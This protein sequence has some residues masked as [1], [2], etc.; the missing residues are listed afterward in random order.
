MLCTNLLAEAV[1]PLELGAVTRANS[2][3]E[4]PLNEVVAVEVGWSSHSN[5]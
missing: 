3:P 1:V 5:K 4:V 2:H